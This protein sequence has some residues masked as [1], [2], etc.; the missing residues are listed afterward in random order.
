MDTVKQLKEYLETMDENEVI[1]SLL[2]RKDDIISI[3]KGLGDSEEL[4]VEDFQEVGLD[5]IMDFIEQETDR[6]DGQIAETVIDM[7]STIIQEYVD[8]SLRG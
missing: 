4:R 5:Y 7:L 2:W 1:I 8:E 6:V 3:A